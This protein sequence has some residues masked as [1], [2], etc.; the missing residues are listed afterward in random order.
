[1]CLVQININ[2]AIK[3][4]VF[5][6]SPA[7]Q[8]FTGIFLKIS[9]ETQFPS[10]VLTSCFPVFLSNFFTTWSSPPKTILL[11]LNSPKTASSSGLPSSSLY[12]FIISSFPWFYSFLVQNLRGLFGFLHHFSHNILI[13]NTN[14][15]EEVGFPRS[16]RDCK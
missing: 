8:I 1:M 5:F 6:F 15:Y 16:Q 3:K 7:I 12:E 11:S 4:F 14:F 9:K 2:L 10:N 13:I